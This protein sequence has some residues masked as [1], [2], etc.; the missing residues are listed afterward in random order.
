MPHITVSSR[1]KLYV[2][3]QRVLYDFDASHSRDWSGSGFNLSL[4]GA[5]L[6][7]AAV[8][9]GRTGKR[10]I[11][12]S[13]D[14]YD[15][16]TSLIGDND[17]PLVWAWVFMRAPTDLTRIFG[18][19]QDGYGNGW[20]MS[21]E[22]NTSRVLNASMV[23]SNPGAAQ[24]T[25]TL[26]PTWRPGWNFVAILIQN[27]YGTE[28][29]H[30]S[31]IWE[32][33]QGRTGLTGWAGLRSSTVG[34]YVGASASKGVAA[35]KNVIG[36]LGVELVNSMTEAQA[37]ARVRE[38]RGVSEPAFRDQR[39]T[40]VYFSSSQYARPISDVTVGTWIGV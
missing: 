31:A 23:T 1:P 11:G 8:P 28:P 14:I 17:F 3:A 16:G 4:P 20:S 37:L 21:L 5:P 25:A 38:I 24:W 22:I 7:D 12:T 39:A 18:R 32:S 40:R 33:T 19:G 15:A 26:T 6:I 30:V 29:S 9:G 27:T 34:S 10:L 2:P 13:Q 36:A 35:S